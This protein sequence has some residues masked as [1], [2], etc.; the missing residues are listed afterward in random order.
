MEDRAIVALYLKRDEDAIAESALKYGARLRSISQGI[1][2][3]APTAEECENDTYFEA[4]RRIPPHDPSEYLFA[5]LARIIRN[6]SIDAL[7]RQNRLKRRADVV[8]LSAEMEA[9]IP[10][11]DDTAARVEA[12]ELGKAVGRYLATLSEEKRVLFVR[13]YWYLD[14]VPSIAERMNMGQSRVKMTLFRVRAGLREFLRKEGYE[15]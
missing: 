3:D 8:Q 11:P 9:C 13:R 10:S 14:S 7:R 12:L 1:V 5:F 4:W 15:L 6:L 2:E